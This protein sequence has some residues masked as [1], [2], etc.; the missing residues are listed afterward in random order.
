MDR[1]CRWE[2]KIY[3][4]EVYHGKA[5]APVGTFMLFFFRRGSLETQT[6]PDLKAAPTRSYRPLPT[7]TDPRALESYIMLLRFPI[8]TDTTSLY[9]VDIYIYIYIYLFIY[10]FFV[11][12]TQPSG[13]FH[14]N[15][16]KNWVQQLAGNRWSVFW[17]THLP[18]FIRQSLTQCQCWQLQ[19]LEH[20]PQELCP[21]PRKAE[22]A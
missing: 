20:I 4:P 6:S 19:H 21:H 3:M 8:A 5:P 11:K 9:L 7:W 1:P 22:V 13:E 14:S 10:L 15:S 17:S 16:T 12:I 2:I 18:H